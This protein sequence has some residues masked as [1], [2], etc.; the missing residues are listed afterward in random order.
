M[1]IFKNG[2]YIIKGD[3]GCEKIAHHGLSYN[4][5]DLKT[6]IKYCHNKRIAVDIGS[7][8]GTATITLSKYFEH[9]Y[10]FELIPEIYECL[11]L[12][13]KKHG[14]EN[15]TNYNQAIAAE[16][17]TA[18]IKI[19]K[20]HGSFGSVADET[21]DSITVKPLDY[22]NFSNVDFIKIDVEGHEL[23]AIQGAIETIERCKPIIMFEALEHI[24]NTYNSSIQQ[25][26]DYLEQ[27]GYEKICTVG[28]NN[29]DIVVGY[30]YD[31][32]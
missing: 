32:R 26:L 12:N 30:N 17:G 31:K 18:C 15:S 27:H 29:H 14:V 28:K 20:S 6:A 2:W 8:I 11:E 19:G 5:Q 16:E 7:H 23:R 9:V 25:I 4:N 22:Y 21:G 13:I 10:S 24:L 1:Q 3:R